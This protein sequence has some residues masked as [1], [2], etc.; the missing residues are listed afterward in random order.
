MGKLEIGRYDVFTRTAMV[1]GPAAADVYDEHIR[2]A[3]EEEHLGYKYYS[4]SSIRP[5]LSAISADRRD[6][7]ALARHTSAIRSGT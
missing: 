5:S 7:T 3:Q 6:L 1:R 4:L 2:T